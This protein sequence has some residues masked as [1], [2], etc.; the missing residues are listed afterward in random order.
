MLKT[1]MVTW[2]KNEFKPLTLATPDTTIEQHIDSAFRYWNTH[3]AYKTISMLTISGGQQYRTQLPNTMKIPVEVYPAT[4]TTW[5]YGNNPIW[6]LLGIQIL[7]NVT[8]D[9][10]YLSQA[11]QN[12]RIYMGTDFV[13]TYVKSDDPANGGYLYYRNIPSGVTEVCVVGTKK[14][15]TTDDIKTE[16]ILDWL[17]LYSK[18]LVK[19]SEGNTLRKSSLINITNDGQELVNEGKAEVE[20]L[21]KRLETEGTWLAMA[22]RF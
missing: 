6:T 2:I 21:Q 17:L 11:Y 10:I 5:P 20:E 1:A 8:S 19:I 18:A 15:F 13:W 14:I 9:L 3:S 4:Q 12:Y 22:L 16:D 7:D